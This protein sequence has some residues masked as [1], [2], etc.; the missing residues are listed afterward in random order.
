MLFVWCYALMTGRRGMGE[1]DSKLLM[2]IGAFLGWQGAAFSLVAG[3]VQG[4]LV[5]GFALVTGKDVSLGAG[6]SHEEDDDAGTAEPEGEP[7]QGAA[8]K[9][10]EAAEDA[11]AEDSEPPPAWFGHLKLPFGPFL[12]L[13]A[14]EHLFFGDYLVSRWMDLS[15]WLASLIPIQ[16]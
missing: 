10:A 8:E 11:A 7:A 14:L 2:M 16:G 15:Q 6:R 12:A 5:A 13:G 3:S 9:R 4:M 1:G